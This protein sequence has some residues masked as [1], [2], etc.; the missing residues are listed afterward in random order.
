MEVIDFSSRFIYEII[1]CLIKIHDVTCELLKNWLNRNKYKPILIWNTCVELW[2]LSCFNLYWWIHSI[3]PCWIKW[4]NKLLAIEHLKFSSKLSLYKGTQN[5]IQNDVNAFATGQWWIK[6]I[7]HM[8]HCLVCSMMCLVPE[9]K[10]KYCAA[11]AA[12]R[13]VFKLNIVIS[14]LS[15]VKFT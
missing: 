9:M 3:G 12:N 10:W 7:P 13:L 14:S 8:L 1:E 4:T 15:I 5:G 2:Q 6:R 11:F